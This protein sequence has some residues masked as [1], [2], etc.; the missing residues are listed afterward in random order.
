M[1]E[2]KVKKLK[3]TQTIEVKTSPDQDRVWVTFERSW[4]PVNY[5]SVKVGVGGSSNVR[6]GETMKQALMRNSR[7]VRRQYRDLCIQTCKEEG[8]ELYDDS[9]DEDTKDMN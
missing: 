7:T 9:E 3:S 2:K 1:P 5:E 8:I 6:P 4:Q